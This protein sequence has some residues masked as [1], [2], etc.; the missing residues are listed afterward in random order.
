MRNSEHF[1]EDKIEFIKQKVRE[2]IDT[3]FVKFNDRTY[4][5]FLQSYFYLEVQYCIIYYCI[6]IL[7]Y[8]RILNTIVEQHEEEHPFGIPRSIQQIRSR[9]LHQVLRQ[10]RVTQT[11]HCTATTPDLKGRPTPF[12]QS[13]LCRNHRIAT[14]S[15]SLQPLPSELSSTYRRKY[16]N[17]MVLQ[18][19][20][21]IIY[22]LLFFILATQ[23]TLSRISL[24]HS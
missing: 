14:Q 16:R 12:L 2:G 5:S 13:P 18:H 6:E 10:R 24:R 22:Y 1:L 4:F 8:D 21:F 3:C 7:W 15:P 19:P 20:L 23:S 11:Q 17:Q 9:V